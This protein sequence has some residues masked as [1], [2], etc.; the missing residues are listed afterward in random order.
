MGPETI[1]LGVSNQH[2]S[3]GPETDVGLGNELAQHSARGLE[4]LLRRFLVS[5]TGKS[6][7]R[8]KASQPRSSRCQSSDP[9]CDYDAIARSDHI[10]TLP[11][12]TFGWAAVLSDRFGVVKRG[13]NNRISASVAVCCGKVSGGNGSIVLQ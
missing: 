7:S 11:A 10:G 12:F 4:R 8:R 13:E 6:K 2:R 5:S 9:F 1:R 3:E